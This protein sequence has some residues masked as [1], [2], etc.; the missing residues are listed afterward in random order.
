MSSRPRLTPP[1]APAQGPLAI[2]ADPH[3]ARQ[4]RQA[5]QGRIAQCRRV[6][7]Y[8][9]LTL[10]ELMPGLRRIGDAEVSWAARAPQETVEALV[11]PGALVVPEALPPGQTAP[12]Q[13]ALPVLLGPQCPELCSGQAL[14]LGSTSPLHSRRWHHHPQCHPK[15]LLAKSAMSGRVGYDA[16]W[17][18][19]RRRLESV[20]VGTT[21]A[22]GA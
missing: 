3:R 7:D 11:I 15:V 17:R 9:P 13:P 4:A 6:Q 19:L 14:P 5:L 12:R 22:Q 20:S 10:K 18:A 2:P 1:L 16:A 8:L 21:R